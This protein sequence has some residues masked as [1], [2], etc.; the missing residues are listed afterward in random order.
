MF[1]I[2]ANCKRGCELPVTAHTALEALVEVNGK[3]QSI[4]HHAHMPVP[5]DSRVLIITHVACTFWWAEHGCFATGKA[6]QAFPYAAS[7][8][9]HVVRG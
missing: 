3:T 8:T 2:A 7:S 4:E 1:L 9:C 6:G 5:A